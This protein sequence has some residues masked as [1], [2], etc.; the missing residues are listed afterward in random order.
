MKIAKKGKKSRMPTLQSVGKRRDTRQHDEKI[1]VRKKGQLK[2]S[3][4]NRGTMSEQRH[5]N[6]LKIDIWT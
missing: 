6:G 4:K 3:P 5:E 1:I 2:T